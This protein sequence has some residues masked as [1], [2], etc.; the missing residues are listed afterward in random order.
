MVGVKE[1]TGVWRKKSEAELKA[2]A[3]SFI[4][5]AEVRATNL[6]WLGEIQERMR[7]KWSSARTAE[8]C[9]QSEMM[10]GLRAAFAATKKEVEVKRLRRVLSLART[11]TV[12]T[13]RASTVCLKGSQSGKETN[14][15]RATTR[16]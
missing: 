3:E 12:C 1:D 7:K 8:Q 16:R 14:T 4:S 11:W 9:G 5:P 2:Q 6:T 10:D 15:G 13:G